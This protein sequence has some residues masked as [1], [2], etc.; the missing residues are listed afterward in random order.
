MRPPRGEPGRRGK[1]EERCRSS[2]TIRLRRV[3][4]GYLV[5]PDVNLEVPPIPE[6]GRIRFPLIDYE[7]DGMPED[8]GRAR[9][10]RGGRG[11]SP[12]PLQLKDAPRCAA[13]RPAPRNVFTGCS[14]SSLVAKR[15][16][17]SASPMTG[18][19]HHRALPPLMSYRMSVPARSVAKPVTARLPHSSDRPPFD[20]RRWSP[21]ALVHAPAIIQ[22]GRCRSCMLGR[23]QGRRKTAWAPISPR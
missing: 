6:R 18:Q 22:Y 19:N 16:G 17:G 4:V 3:G 21:R 13:T 11:F 7:L 8:F 1:R 14:P 5:C 23:R 15:Q 10:R 2:R 12:V 20:S 9:W